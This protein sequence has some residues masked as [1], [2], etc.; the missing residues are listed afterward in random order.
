[1]NDI[2]NKEREKKIVVGDISRGWPK[3][4]FIHSY[5]TEV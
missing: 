2:L 3:G 5:Y 4:S 1:M